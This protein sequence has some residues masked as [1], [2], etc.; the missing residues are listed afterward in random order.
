M[1]LAKLPLIV[2]VHGAWHRPNSFKKLQVELERQGYEVLCPALVTMSKTKENAGATHL[3]D[4]ALIHELLRPHLDQG[5]EVVIVG[6]SY[7]GVPSVVSC[8][9]NTVDERAAQ[10]KK[11]GIR[12]IVFIAAIVLPARGLK[13]LTAEGADWGDWLVLNDG[14]REAL[15]NGVP[16]AEVDEIMSTLVPIS[17]ATTGVTV[18]FC[19]NDL[20][21]PKTYIFCE[22]DQALPPAAQE[23]LIAGTPNMTV[24]RVQT[25]HFPWLIVPD[26]IA[27]VIVRASK[28]SV[29]YEMA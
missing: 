12:A 21:I 23:T 26:E 3:D 6:H 25:C 27:E 4:V 16:E 15:Y 28:E 11:G 22:L 14:A 5:R 19:A 9:G 18:D 2:L 13:I 10:G 20:K 7:G 17:S 29:T 8:E 1:T 24:V